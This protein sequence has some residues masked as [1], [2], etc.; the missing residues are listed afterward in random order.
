MPSILALIPAR[1]GSKGLRRKNLRL[2]LGKSLVAHAIEAATASRQVTDV[3]VS[4]EDAD[5]ATEARRLGARVID[6]PAALASDSAQNDAVAI[7]AL[8]SLGAAH[9]PDVLLLLQ[10][11]S[12]LRTSAHIDECVT[13]LLASSAQSA[14]SICPASHHPSKYVVADAGLVRPYAGEVEFEARRQNLTPVFRQNG[15]IYAVHTPAFLKERK[16]YIRPCMGYVMD[17]QASIDIDGE[18]DLKIAEMVAAG[19]LHGE[20]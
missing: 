17:E 1:G 6:R 2:V 9:H 5:I 20:G 4:T 8:E 14:M 16:F 18:L 11:T 10:P 7:H 12:P 15:A 19:R 3:A 13:L